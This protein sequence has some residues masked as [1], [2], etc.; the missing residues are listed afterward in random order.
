MK[1]TLYTTIGT[2]L[3]GVAMLLFAATAVAQTRQLV[4]GKVTDASGAPMVGVTVIE[5]GTSNGVTTGVD[6]SY[7]ITVKGDNSTLTFS[8]LGYSSQRIPVGVRNTIDATLS[9]DAINMSEVVVT[10]YGRTVTKDKLTAAVSKVSG[11]ILESGV[12]SNALQALSGSVTGVRVATTSGQPGQAPNI[13][14]R[15]GAALDGTGKPLYVIDGVQ[16]DDMNDINSNDIESIEVLKDAAATALYGAKANAGVVL[17]TTKSGRVGKAEISFKANYGLNY[18]RKTNEFLAA[19]DYLYYMRLA[20]YRSG[21]I[22]SLTAAGPYGTGND[23]YAD[24]NKKAEGIYSTM[25]LSDDNRFLLDQG[26]RTMIDPITG[27]SLIYSAFTPS[28]DSVREVATTQD[29]NVSISGGNEKGKYYASLGY[30]DETGF[31]LMS[32][33]NRLSFTTNGSYKVT[34]WLT[35]NSAFSFTKSESRQVSDYRSQGESEFFG[36]MFS[37]PPTMRQ[38]NLDG[39]LIACTTNY[40]NG[41]WAAT[42]DKFYRRN[43][44]YR[45]TMSQGLKFDITDHL[46]FKVNGMWYFNMVEKEAFNKAFLSKAGTTDTNRKASASYGRMLSQT[47]NAIGSYENSWNDHNLSVIAG[48]EFY[49]RTSFGLSAAGQGADSDDFISLGY[50]SKVGDANIKAL[51]MNSTHTKERSMSVFGNASYD[52]KSKYLFSFSMR[53]DGYSKLVNN[54]WGFFPGVSAAW[55]IHKEKFMESTSSWLSSLKLRAGYGQNGNVNIVAGPYDLQGN[56]GKTPTYDDEYGIL[57][58][59]LPYPDLRWEK[60]TSVDVAVEASFWNRLRVSIGGYRKLTSDLLATVPFPSSA[61]VTNQYTNNGSVRNSGLEIEA[62][63]TIYQDKNWKIRMGVNATYMRSKI[64]SLPD[65]GNENNRQN[66]QQ[67]YDPRT[68]QLTW[69]G[70]YQQGQE[71]GEAYSYQMVGIV[72][73]DADLQNYA[74]YVDKLPSTP[75]YGPSAWATLTPEEQSKSTLLRPGD[76]IF[77]DVNGDNVIDSYDQVSMG[78]VVPRWVGGANLSVDWKGLTL[79]ARFDFAGDYV[80]YNSRKQ[81]YMAL[82]QGTFNTLKESKDTW[83]EQRPDAKYPILMY[84]DG[85][86]R[87]NFRASNIFYDNSSYLCAREISLS[88]SLPKRWA[89]KVRMQ[90]L[91]VSITGQNLFYLTKSSLYNPEYGVDGDG[92][93]ATPRT[94]LFGIKATF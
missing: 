21:N 88:Y 41:N 29:Y 72:R 40:Q 19:D 71:Y 18:L 75:I 65:N 15:G 89:N 13:V 28:D 73:S 38:Y 93:Y 35:S 26:Y 80:A 32:E 2:L 27:K 42:I 76:A 46:S 31:P 59:K 55:N 34:P 50:V 16:K 14:I 62:D 51:A 3:L 20:A 69:V 23:Y 82:S 54:K 24:G 60:T 11:E 94:V 56:Y 8:S 45:F 4:S 37:A 7:K 66:G 92:G 77:Y 33:Y 53:Y 1:P 25:F 52:Y 9:E 70:G 57:I 84:A 87:K 6:G 36:I 17:V 5:Q 78:H 58:N 43:T 90:N 12:R 68:G 48:F 39:E 44:N 85:S 67:V 49:D 63:A 79:F 61:G 22:S 10:G 86:N 74:W 47:Y 64:V 91:T 81:W 83:S 30:Y